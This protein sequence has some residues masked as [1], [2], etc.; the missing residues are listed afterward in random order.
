MPSFALGEA[1]A[2][3]AALPGLEVIGSDIVP[4]RKAI[5]ATLFG[6]G[7]MAELKAQFKANDVELV[8]VDGPVT[9]VQ[10]RNMEKEWV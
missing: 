9:P 4:V 5:P 10:Q 7:K 8:L 6:K 2:L 3:G 1:V